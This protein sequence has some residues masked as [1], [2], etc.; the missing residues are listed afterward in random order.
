MG[1]ALPRPE[2]EL[3]SYGRSLLLAV[4]GALMVLVFLT[5]TI[6]AL[7]QF[8]PSGPPTLALASVLPMDFWSWV[9]AAETAAWRLKWIA[10][11]VTIVAL[12]GTKIYDQGLLPGPL[13]CLR[14]TG[15]A[16]ALV[17]AD[18]VLIGVTV[19]SACDSARLLKRHTLVV[20][21]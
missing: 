2:H 18:S 12:W 8:A 21:R 4:T 13:L 10:I 1:E 14:P 5:Q 15:Y 19:P 6:I 7:V 17:P 11:P 20:I 9:A 3:P 16:S